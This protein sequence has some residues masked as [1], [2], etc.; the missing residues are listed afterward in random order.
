MG[1]TETHYDKQQGGLL[2]FFS[3]EFGSIELLDLAVV[4]RR[5][6]YLACRHPEPGGNGRVWAAVVL[7]RFTRGRMNIMYKEMDE[8]MGPSESS[9]PERILQ[10]LTPLPDLTPEAA[11]EIAQL[12]AGIDTLPY[13]M[14]F[15]G[16]VAPDLSV[17]V[18]WPP[19]RP[20][21]GRADA[22]EH[23]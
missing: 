1:W 21:G 7:L 2:D 3:R 13:R 19:N 10:R 8:G 14:G 23:R 4:Q 9:C 22:E 12:R 5:V 16:T 11:S 18:W 20:K 17:G 15:G 6:A